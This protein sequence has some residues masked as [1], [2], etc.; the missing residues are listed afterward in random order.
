MKS[1]FR[2][3]AR[4]AICASVVISSGC[5][6]SEGVYVTSRDSAATSISETDIQVVKEVCAQVAKEFGMLPTP[7]SEVETQEAHFRSVLP[8][9]RIIASYDLPGNKVVLGATSAPQV[10]KFQAQL[11][12]AVGKSHHEQQIYRRIVELLNQRLGPGRAKLKWQVYANFA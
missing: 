4:A 5:F 6:V 8:G 12:I 2:Q 9:G 1:T 11:V 3:L 7:A 10:Q